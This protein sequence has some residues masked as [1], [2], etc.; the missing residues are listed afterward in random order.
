MS[1][2]RSGSQGLEGLPATPSALAPNE[3]V[4][5]AAADLQR[6]VHV[7]PGRPRI[8]SKACT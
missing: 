2:R 3:R 5:A 8:C 7:K 6:G 4:S 1:G